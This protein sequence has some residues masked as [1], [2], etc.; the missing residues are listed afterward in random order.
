MNQRLNALILIS[1][2]F[3]SL[4]PAITSRA[5]ETPTWEGQIVYIGPDGNLWLLRG[6]TPQPFQLTNDASEVRRY[7]SPLFSPRGDLLAYCQNDDSGQGASQLYLM[8]ASSWQPI[9]IAD[10]L[11]CQHWPQGSFSWSPDGKQIAYAR[12]FE[13]TPQADGS[14]WSQYHGIWTVDV[15]SGNASELVPPPGK[16]PLV[17]PSWSPDGNWLRMY[18]SVYL[19][20][21]GVLRTWERQ[22][23]AVYN[24]LEMGTDIF[25]GFADWSPDGARLV[26]DEV[27]YLGYPDAGIFT[28]APGGGDL[29]QV[30][31]NPDQAALHP[32]WSPDGR[33]LAFLIYTYG[34]SPQNIIAVSAPDGSNL[35]WVFSAPASLE[36][37]DWSPDG[38]QLLFASTEVTDSGEQTGLFIYDLDSA[39]HFTAALPG[40]K[41]ADWAPTYVEDKSIPGGKPGEIPDFRAQGSPLAYLANNYQLMLYDPASGDQAELSPPLVARE[42]WA[43]PSGTRLV[44]A[45]QLVLLKVG[46]DGRV[47]QTTVGLPASPSGES[48]TWSSDETRLAFRDGLGS[49]WMVQVGGDF[50]EIPGASSLPTWSFDG[51]YLS[52]CTDGDRMWAVGGGISLRQV[53]AGVECQG[54]AAPQ[55]SPSQPLLVYT[56]V[57]SGTQNSLVYVYDAERGESDPAMADVELIG[58]SPDGNLLG[59]RQADSTGAK[60]FTDY[61]LEPKR[62][63]SLEVG[64]IDLSKPGNPGWSEASQDYI[65]G[66][67][68]FDRRLGKRERLVETLFDAAEQGRILLI[69][70]ETGGLQ[71]VL[72]QDANADEPRSLLSANL[73]GIPADEKPGLWAWLAPDG[74]WS[75]AYM[76]DPGGYRYLLTRCDRTRQI[77]LES[78]LSPENDAFSPDGNWFLQLPNAGGGASQ[79]LVYNLDTLERQ[80]L[81]MLPASKAVWVK[82]PQ[83]TVQTT[84]S[85]SGKVSAADGSPLA[86]VAILVDGEPAAASDETGAFTLADL[87]AGEHTI[88]ASLDGMQ[89]SP[90][91]VSIS[92][93]TPE[94]EIVFT[95]NAAAEGGAILTEPAPTAAGEEDQGTQ[96]P[97]QGSEVSTETDAS[98]QA[99]GSNIHLR[100][101]AGNGAGWL[102]DYCADGNL[103]LADAQPQARSAHSLRRW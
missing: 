40:G 28:A 90:T 76:F 53:A 38:R 19:E 36:V 34:D 64:S 86:G 11:Y 74:V 103:D 25:P 6:D 44:Y 16:N 61:A 54:D 39:S 21:L 79:L 47:T 9:Q 98:A 85:V 50:V 51:R 8:R 41:Q 3:Y 93:P 22:S 60:T 5:Q 43:S 24:W 48:V 56:Q 33:N 46:E 35:V 82:T 18:E 4:Y 72:C 7:N 14:Q 96:V 66:A 26:F 2:F 63:K 45:D 58:W 68:Q 80:N 65:L 97:T 69:G 102:A 100:K 52:Y 95:A 49:V 92:I 17:L 91:S 10:D 77:A 12:S 59:L 83:I 32:L 30:F 94:E 31:T 67:Y 29:K 37:L 23:G 99:P 78:S 84:S 75:A 73:S 27:T 88:S 20:G 55:W 81:G 101:H 13:Y 42:Y 15:G 57:V 87:V 71:E 62:G 89:F 70:S 1:L